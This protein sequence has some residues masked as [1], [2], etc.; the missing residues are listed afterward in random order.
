[1]VNLLMDRN[2]IEELKRAMLLSETSKSKL[3]RESGLSRS[4][5]GD[6]FDEEQDVGSVEAWQKVANALGKRIRFVLEEETP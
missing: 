4:Y 5:I 1:M 3:A 2:I 6:M